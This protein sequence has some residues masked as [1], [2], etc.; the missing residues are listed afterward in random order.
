MPPL[1]L[2]TR[3]I[4]AAARLGSLFLL[5]EGYADRAILRDIVSDKS[6]YFA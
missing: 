3:G 1:R 5:R 4:G 2:K 6:I